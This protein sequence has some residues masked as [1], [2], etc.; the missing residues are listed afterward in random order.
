[1]SFALPFVYKKL[2]PRAPKPGTA[3]SPDAPAPSRAPRF[4]SDLLQGILDLRSRQSQTEAQD[5][6]QDPTQTPPAQAERLTPAGTPSQDVS[7]ATD[8]EKRQMLSNAPVLYDAQK[9]Y[10]AE[11]AKDAARQSC[12]TAPAAATAGSPAAARPGFRSALPGILEEMQRARSRPVADRNGRLR[13]AAAMALRG[14]AQGS[15]TGDWLGG[16]GG[17]AAGAVVGGVKPSSDEYF[18]QQEQLARLGHDF[19]QTAAREKGQAQ[20][21][22]IQA[23][24]A[25]RE[26]AASNAPQTAAAKATSAEMREIGQR[27]RW[28]GGT[29]KP[30]K[31]ARLDELVTKHGADPKRAGSRGLDARYIKTVKDTVVYIDPQTGNPLPLYSADMSESDRM[32]AAVD[33]EQLNLSRARAG[34]GPYRYNEAGVLSVDEGAVPAAAAPASPSSGPAPAP[35]ARPSSQAP[36]APAPGASPRPAGGLPRGPVL[37]P[38]GRPPEKVTPPARSGY[39]PRPSSRGGQPSND[40][41]AQINATV[42]TGLIRDI[43]QARES[44]ARAAGKGD[45]NAK[46]SYLQTAAALTEAARKNPNLRGVIEVGGEKDSLGDF[47]PSVGFR[48]QTGG[49]QSG[50][51]PPASQ[52]SA[53]AGRRMSRANVLKYARDHKMKAADAARQLQSQGITIY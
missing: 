29:Y 2:P 9:V 38:S 34:L 25:Q 15:R 3:V 22:D 24:T 20:I 14:L 45:L 4:S 7:Y 46:R 51:Q 53:Y 32:R 52:P 18:A 50:G 5:D 35:A 13:S 10:E 1:M 21:E 37:V 6:G 8:E 36:T 17:A 12:L 40:K 31:D 26:A 47:W 43:E 49:A 19:D 23:Q 11:Q 16:L 28:M 44:A 30:G 33:L 48:A 42:A 41:G 39:G 27:L